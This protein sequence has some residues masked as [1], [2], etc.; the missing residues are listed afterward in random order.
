M[1][2]TYEGFLDIF[3]KE[4]EE[5]MKRVFVDKFSLQQLGDLRVGD[6]VIAED[7]DY[8]IHSVMEFIR[9]NVGKIVAIWEENEY[10]YVVEYK[11]IPYEDKDEFVRLR[12]KKSV[13]RENCWTFKREEIKYHGTEQEMNEKIEFIKNIKKFNL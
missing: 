5:P 4:V 1:I 9:T 11:N 6:Y 10:P 12:N 3:R 2:R 8:D 7:N 13:F